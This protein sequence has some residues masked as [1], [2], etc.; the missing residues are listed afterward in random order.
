MKTRWA[1]F[2]S[3]LILQMSLPLCAPCSCNIPTTLLTACSWLISMKM[4]LRQFLFPSRSQPLM[5]SYPIWIGVGINVFDRRLSWRKRAR[6]CR[7]CNNA[8]TIGILNRR[9]QYQYPCT[10]DH[11]TVLFSIYK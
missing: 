5:I 11:K 9:Y 7:L 4:H 8:W 3:K 10:V 2:P 1:I 6:S